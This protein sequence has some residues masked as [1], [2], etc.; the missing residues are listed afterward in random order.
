MFGSCGGVAG[1]LLKVSVGALLAEVS[2]FT[3]FIGADTVT[4]ELTSLEPPLLA[5]GSLGGL[6]LLVLSF[7]FKKLNAPLDL[8]PEVVG[9]GAAV[10][11]AETADVGGC[12]LSAAPRGT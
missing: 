9:V 2:F 12:F 11:G 8:L 7:F 3:E 1:V 6:S 4:G 10:E 5:L